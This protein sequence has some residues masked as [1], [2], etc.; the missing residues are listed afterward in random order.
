MTLMRYSLQIKQLLRF[1]L[2]PPWTV[3]PRTT[4]DAT[5]LGSRAP[6]VPLLH[7]AALRAQ[8][9]PHRPDVAVP[10]RN[11]N[12]P[13]ASAQAATPPLQPTWRG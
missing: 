10:G 12:V 9:V 1:C 8:Q 7:G 3:G 4:P 5:H 2:Q 11:N 13:V 6:P